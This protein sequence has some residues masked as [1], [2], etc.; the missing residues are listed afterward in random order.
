NGQG[1][2]TGGA[3][4]A[5][6]CNSTGFLRMFNPFQD[7]PATATCAGV[8]TYVTNIIKSANASGAAMNAMLKGQ[9][10]ATSL[11]VY[12]SDPTLGGNK[13]NAPTPLGVVKI[14]LTQVC[15]MIDGS[16]GGVCTG[17]YQNA[18]SA[19]GSATSMTVL[20]MLLFQN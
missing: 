20:N 13:I 11:D 6:V 7:L 3:S 5:G 15:A 8:G 17:V 18:S 19:F 12:F 9:M 2:I 14:D 4:T 1:I 16:G 10:L